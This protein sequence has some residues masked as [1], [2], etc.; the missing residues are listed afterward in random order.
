MKRLLFLLLS[1]IIITSCA[2]TNEQIY[3]EN[4]EYGHRLESSSIQHLPKINHQEDISFDL[5]VHVLTQDTGYFKEYERR[6][7]V[8]A[9]GLASRRS[10][11][12]HVWVPG[13]VWKDGKYIVPQSTLG[14]EVFHCIEF[15]NKKFKHAD[16][17]KE[18]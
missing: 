6:T 1:S 14:H 16:K 7:G 10:D 5:K 3:H 8:K 4:L 13:F 15:Y 9:F 18:D 12:C 2:F 17:L 11:G